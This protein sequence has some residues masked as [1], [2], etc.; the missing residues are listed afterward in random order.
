MNHKYT[1]VYWASLVAQ[2]V[3]KKKTCLQC[4]RPGFNPWVGKLPWKRERL[5][6]PVFLPVK[7]TCF[8]KTSTHFFYRDFR[9]LTPHERN[10][11]YH[12]YPIREILPS[13]HDRRKNLPNQT[14]ILQ[15]SKGSF[16]Y[17]LHCLR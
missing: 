8:V 13:V 4:K 10:Y 16:S 17:L 1:Y 15:L 14:M 7:Q 6:T 11:I 9:N 5:P 2:M 3:K 12:T